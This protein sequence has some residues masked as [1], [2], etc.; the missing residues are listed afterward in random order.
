[1]RIIYFSPHPTH[2]IVS[3]VGYSTH[4]REMIMALRELGHDVIPVIIGGATEDELPVATK[5][6]RPNKAVSAIKSWVPGM[7]WRTLKDARLMRHD[8]TIAGPRL[9]KALENNKVDLVYERSEYFLGQG[10]AIA[11]EAGVKHIYEVNA[12]CVEEWLQFE[13]PSMFTPKAR[14][15]EKIK[16]QNSDGLCPV[17]SSLGG[18]LKKQYGLNKDRIK[19]IT[20]GINPNAVKVN[21][22]E[23]DRIRMKLGLKDDQVV[24]GF[25]GSILKYHGVDKLIET[26]ARV[27]TERT[28]A[29]LMI[30]GDGAMLDELKEQATK[31]D[32]MDRCRFVGRIPHA[33]VFNYMT[34]MHICVSP[35]HSWYGSPIKLFEYAYLG[36]AIIAPD[37]ENISDVLTNNETALLM[38]KGAA[39]LSTLLA[40]LIDSKDLRTQL[41]D[42]AKKLIADNYTWESNA[43]QLI[44]F[45][46]LIG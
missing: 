39:N 36:K 24:V 20:N 5:T 26:F 25:V 31:M 12:P 44:E 37:Q 28:E 17:S 18:V 2:D 43:A 22:V 30:V 33:E 27:A 10:S 35:T 34:L 23:V 4:Q 41:G 19:T 7:V 42:A 14:K 8:K 38:D 13:G 1:M 11:A 15:I 29:I 9:R 45:A 32:I 46:N 3:D 21:E 16:Y 40:K 6:Q